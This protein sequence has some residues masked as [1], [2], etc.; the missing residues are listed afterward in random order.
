MDE[1]PVNAPFSTREANVSL[2]RVIGDATNGKGNP[3]TRSQK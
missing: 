3:R 2:R 1:I